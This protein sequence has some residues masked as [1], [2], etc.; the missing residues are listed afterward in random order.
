MVSSLISFFKKVYQHIL[1]ILF[2]P[3]CVACLAPIK[4]QRAYICPP[5]FDKISIHT[6]HTC[7]ACGKRKAGKDPCHKTPYTLAAACHYHEP[8]PELIHYFKYK[9]LEAIHRILSA[10]LIV[11]AQKT[12]PHIQSYCVSYIPI[13]PRKERERGFNQTYILAQTVANYFHIPCVSLLKRTRYTESQTKQKGYTERHKNIQHCF[14]CID[15]KNIAGKNIIL[16]DDVCTS[17]ATLYEATKTIRLHHPRHVI[18]LVI[19]KVE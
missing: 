2:P 8:I 17:G 16:V 4:D 1:N 12:I 19:A 13:H 10:L 9:K 7:P 6:T 3:V 5:C 14:V 11:H 18:G 15:S